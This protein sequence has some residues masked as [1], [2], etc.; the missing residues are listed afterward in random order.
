M[1]C[2]CSRAQFLDLASERLRHAY[3]RYRALLNAPKLE[4]GHGD[5]L[6]QPTVR[7]DG[8][9]APTSGHMRQNAVNGVEQP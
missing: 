6:P 2:F 9:N 7:F 1:G 3:D 4:S 8:H 5:S